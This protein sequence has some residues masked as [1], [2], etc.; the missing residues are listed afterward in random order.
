M[1]LKI[2]KHQDGICEM[3]L[4]GRISQTTVGNSVDQFSQLLG[5]ANYQQKI[6]VSLKETDYIDSSGIG[7]LLATDKKIRNA[8][9]QLVLHSVPIDVQHV[10][11]LMKLHKVLSIVKDFDEAAASV[12]DFDE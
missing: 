5:E 9:G 4:S 3:S 2:D 11:G 12:R 10:F 8:G 7:W 6:L 1:N